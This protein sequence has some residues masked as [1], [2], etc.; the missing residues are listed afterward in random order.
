MNSKITTNSQLSTPEPKKQKL[1]RQLE[2]EQ[3]HRNGHHMED[4][5]GEGKGEEWGE[6][7]RE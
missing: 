3:I 6:R 2:Q 5:R 4:Y 1:S 7:Y